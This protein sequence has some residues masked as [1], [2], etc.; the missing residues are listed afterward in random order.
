MMLVLEDMAAKKRAEAKQLWEL[1]RRNDP[2]DVGAVVK[3]GAIKKAL[4]AESEAADLDSQIARMQLFPELQH[5][6]YRRLAGEAEARAPRARMNM[7][8]A[9]R[10]ATFPEDSYDVPMS[11]LIIRGQE[12]GGKAMSMPKR[13][14]NALGQE[15]PP[16]QYE[17][18]HAEAQRVA[19]LP[20]EQGGLGLPANNT[21]MDRAR[22]MGFDTDA[23][24]G[25][26][27]DITE[28]GKPK[29]AGFGIRS[30]EAT[31]GLK[32]SFTTDSPT[33]ASEY[34]LQANR[35]KNAAVYP[36]R[37]N[38]GDEVGYDFTSDMYMRN[39]SYLDDE[40]MRPLGGSQWLDTMPLYNW[41][42]DV[43][44][45]SVRMEGVHDGAGLSH[46]FPT[47]V[48]AIIDPKNIRSRFAAFNPAKR[49]SA[50]IL[51]SISPFAVPM[52]AGTLGAV[53]LTGS[54]DASA[55]DWPQP[56]FGYRPDGT[57][58]G[59]G[60]LG[61]LPMADGSVVTEYSMQ[62]RAVK[63]GDKMVEFP[64]LVP[65]LSSE[66]V[67]LM[68]SDIIPNRKPIPE[69]IVQKA[70][71]HAKGRLNKGLSPFKELGK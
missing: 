36:V 58:K 33:Q 31:T 23:F 3:P 49:D 39:R 32:P 46:N 13:P 14:V 18:A 44:A 50:D 65:T 9:Q 28:F 20:V 54:E 42:K 12:G 37:I 66:E 10:R 8:P 59:E 63:V 53:A 15:I 70:I 48:T 25:T 43:G 61:V 67:N 24:H 47:T 17:L 16:T 52:A 11:D 60:W 64:T 57:P 41:A 26:R 5:D 55:S 30:I 2:L 62:S 34:A 22:A 4:A 29:R 45:K 71:E 51:A 1:G 68:L 27:S 6:A 69:P 19:A 40:Y 21:A 38:R 35:G 7:T 56:R